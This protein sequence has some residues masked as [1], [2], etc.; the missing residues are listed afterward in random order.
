MWHQVRQI[1][2][3]R[4]KMSLEPRPTV[5]ESQMIELCEFVIF[6]ILQFLQYVRLPMEKLTLQ[7]IH[8]WIPKNNCE[9]EFGRLIF[10]L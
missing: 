8:L 1:A 9:L 4:Q 10:C 2:V 3:L 6:Y 7:V 5:F